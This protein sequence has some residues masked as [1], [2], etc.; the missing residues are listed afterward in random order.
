MLHKT[1]GIVFRFTKYGETSIIVNIF[2]EIFG[3]QGYIV[4]GVRSKS[5]SNKIALYQPLTLLDL[6]VYYRENANINRIKEVKCLHPYQS[7]P[8]DIRKSASAIFIIEVI[9]K[10]IKEESHAMELCNFIIDSLITLDNIT[11]N[12]E[13]FHLIFLLK[14]SRL[15][16]FGAHNLSEV[17]GAR[18]TDY[19]REQLLGQLIKSDYTDSL[20]LTNTQRRDILDLVLRFYADHIDPLGEWRSVQVLRDVLG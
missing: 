4:N 10:T 16:G 20:R 8:L 18:A 6:V 12:V 2:T 17:M 3:L 19:E 7:I 13:N 1:R 5:G 11:V 15:L 9:N 14:L